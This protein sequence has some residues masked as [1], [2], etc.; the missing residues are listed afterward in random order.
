MFLVILIAFFS[1]IGLVTLHELGHF[2]LAKKFGV[3]VEEFGLGYPPRIFGKKIGETVYSLNL[4]P[5]GAFVRLPGEIE[6]VEDKRSFSQQSVGK[7]ALITLGGVLSFWV[8]AIV[9]FSIVFSL[10]T[11]VAV[12]DEV[13]HNLI[14]PE[15][16]I[17][18]ISPNSPA[19]SAKLIAGD[20]IIKMRSAKEEIEINKVS[21]VKNFVNDNLGKEISITIKRGNKTFDVSLVPRPS[22]PKN[23]GPIGIVLLRTALKKYPWWQAPWQ[24][25]LAAGNIT[26]TIVTGWGMI[27]KNIIKGMPSGAQLMGPVGILNLFTQVSQLGTVYFIQFVGIISMYLAIF[28]ILPI[29]ALDGG[30]LLFLGIEALRKKPVNE[31]TEQNITAFFFVLLLIL[32]GWATVKDIM[33]IF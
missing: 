17:A 23:D 5:F 13:N 20:A 18:G 1:L 33:R 7:R 30:K 6:K 21:E 14:N 4:L 26:V 2:I 11:R 22:P 8:I 10:G 28:N 24:G 19:E 16:Q 25:I 12:E 31:K 15:V 29:P 3:K 32:I 27:I 9:L